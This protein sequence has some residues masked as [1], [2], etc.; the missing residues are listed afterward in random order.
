MGNVGETTKSKFLE[1]LQRN[2]V[3]YVY[4]N[5]HPELRAKF[6]LPVLTEFVRSL[7]EGLGAFVKPDPMN[8]EK[9]VAWSSGTGKT[10]NQ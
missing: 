9:G 3:A 4:N 8:I 7:N 6:E 2:D 10:K 5:F 1:P